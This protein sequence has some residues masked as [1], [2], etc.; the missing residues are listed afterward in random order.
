VSAGWS[1]QRALCLQGE[2]DSG[3]CVCGLSRRRALGLHS[4]QTWSA[5]GLGCVEGH[6]ADG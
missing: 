4:Q 2:L 6:H 5:L 3:H 1:G